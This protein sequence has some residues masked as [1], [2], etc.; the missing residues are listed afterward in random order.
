[1]H[2]QRRLWRIHLHSLAQAGP[3]QAY[4]MRMTYRADHVNL[5]H[6]LHMPE[7]TLSV[8]KHIIRV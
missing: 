2:S 8:A 5:E 6:R 4:T 1:M 7:G 3:R